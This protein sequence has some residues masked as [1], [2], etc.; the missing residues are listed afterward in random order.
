MTLE[1]ILTPTRCH[2]K[3]SVASKGKLLSTLS[4]IIALDDKNFDVDDVF[5]ALIE[6]ERLGTTGLSK[7]VAIPH[8]KV[9]ECTKVTGFLITLENPIDFGASDGL[10]VD[11][12]FALVAPS[13]ND[14]QLGNILAEIVNFLDDDDFCFMARQTF[15]NEDLYN[16]AIMA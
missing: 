8:C 10:P 9:A 12:I 13:S 4:N 1:E 15:D 3:I 14:K 11:L 7:G 5:S 2:N 6:R 16:V